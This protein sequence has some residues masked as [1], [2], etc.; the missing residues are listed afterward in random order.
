V[1][2]ALACAALAACWTGPVAPARPE[3]SAQPAHPVIDLDVKMERTG[4]FGRCPTYSV[5]IHHDGTVVWHGIA[6]VETI[7]TATSRVS[8]AELQRLAREI[9]AVH[10]FE[11]DENGHMPVQPE[12]VRTG[13]TTTCSLSS[14]TICSDTPSAIVSV[15]TSR[16]THT[17]TDDHCEERELLEPLEQLIDHI[18]GSAARIG[19]YR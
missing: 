11:L 10:F 7:G 2:R 13:T 15:R 17:A 19:R 5:E 6:N 9:H 14:V 8:P 12:C 4:C 1:T 3:P 18:A 16:R